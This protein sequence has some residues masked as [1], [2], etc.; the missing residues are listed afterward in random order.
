MK[1]RWIAQ[2]GY[3][4]DIH[5]KQV[6]LDPYLSD[7][8]ERV[9]NAPRMVPAPIAPCE[10]HPDYMLVT[11]DHMDHLDP[12]LAEVMDTSNVAFICPQEVYDHL[13]KL[14][15]NVVPEQVRCVQA[16]DIVECD[17][18]TVTAAFAEHTPQAVGYV[19]EIQGKRYY[20]TGDTLY[21]EKVGADVNADV[22]FCCINGRAGNMSADEAVQVALRSGASLAIP[23]HYGLFQWNTANPLSFTAPAQAAGLNTLVLD[24]AVWV[25]V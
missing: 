1:I 13:R 20:F 4:M 14:N 9:E 16:G 22:I 5:G 18:F 21:S 25:E 3:E 11:H 23:N 2:G 8:C 24:H 7:I 12:D 10:C 19:L 6:L 15:P 17:G